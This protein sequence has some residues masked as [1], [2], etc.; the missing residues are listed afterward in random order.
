VSGRLINDPDA[1][2]VL[3]ARVADMTGIPATHI[4]KDFWVTEVLRGVVAAA[5]EHGI[6]VWFKG[7]TS[8]S[9]VFSMIHRF[10]EDVDMLAVLP[11][12]SGGAHDRMLKALVAGAVQTTGIDGTVDGSGTTKG[13][14]RAV[15]FH[16]RE[17]DA[18][19]YG[20]T[21]GVLLEIGTRGGA[22]SATRATV[23]S[24]IA[25]HVAEIAS[26]PEA[27]PVEVHVLAPWRTLAEKLVLLHTAHTS[28]DPAT[29]VKGA[30]HFYDVYQLLS[31]PEVRSGVVE[32]GI[33]ALARDV[34]TYSRAAGLP[35]ED[36]PP[37]GFA[38]SPAFISSP[39]A[40]LVAAEYADRVVGQLLWPGRPHPSL[41]DCVDLVL[42]HGDIL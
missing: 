11:A 21:A 1:V 36:R 2:A 10:S 18:A 40:D 33:G 6:E 22:L 30:R 27:A 35:A 25:D 19:G 37:T 23:R 41:E 8:L 12:G 31:R 24:M 13:V 39:H 28:P 38:A 15:R 34:C 42:A 20:L 17:S 14:K 9:K 16:Y 29:A 26:E 32:T 4:E 7:G 3:A 5:T